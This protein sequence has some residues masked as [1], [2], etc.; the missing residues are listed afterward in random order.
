[1]ISFSIFLLA[2]RLSYFLFQGHLPFTSCQVIF[3]LMQIALGS[4][5][6]LSYFSR[7]DLSCF[8]SCPALLYTSSCSS[9]PASNP[10]QF[11][12]FCLF[13]TAGS[14]HWQPV[15]FPI[16]SGGPVV[17]TTAC[18]VRFFLQR[19]QIV[20]QLSHNVLQTNQTGF[21][22]FQL[23]DRFLFAISITDNTG[24]LFK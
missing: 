15:L 6:S 18:L 9:K 4:F 19:N 17:Q 22:T 20:F 1:M 8:N 12:P 3:Q 23:P 14:D 10:C 11:F 5:L 21:R 16:V 7:E 2:L 13:Q 24:C